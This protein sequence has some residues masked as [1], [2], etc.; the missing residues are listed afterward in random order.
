M[1]EQWFYEVHTTNFVSWVVDLWSRKEGW[2]I[3]WTKIIVCLSITIY[4]KKVCLWHIFLFLV[5][6]ELPTHNHDQSPICLYT[7]IHNEVP[8]L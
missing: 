4:W 1:Y 7:E 8:V 6:I 3:Q 2:W 5:M